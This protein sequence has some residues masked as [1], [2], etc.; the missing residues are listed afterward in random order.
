MKFF[1]SSC[2]TVII[3]C[4]DINKSMHRLV[5]MAW[6]TGMHFCQI[7]Y[8]MVMLWSSLITLA[9]LSNNV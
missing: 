4:L 8:S 1:I 3:E 6:T 9:F 2:Q 7:V 5:M